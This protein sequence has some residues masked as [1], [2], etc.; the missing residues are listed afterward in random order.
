[1]RKR[2]IAAAPTRFSRAVGGKIRMYPASLTSAEKLETQKGIRKRR[3]TCHPSRRVVPL[4]ECLVLKTS[5]QPIMRLSPN[6]VSH[7]RGRA[8]KWLATF[9]TYQIA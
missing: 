6:E 1:M 4:L 3:K 9:T 7:R 5:A 8:S 2:A